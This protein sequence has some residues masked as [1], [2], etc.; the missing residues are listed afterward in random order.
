MEETIQYFVLTREPKFGE[1]LNWIKENGL[2]AEVHLNRT[3]FWVPSK[4]VIHFVFMLKYGSIC[5]KVNEDE[6][7]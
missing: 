6:L 4:S 1:V 2:K 7:L 3:R 5:N